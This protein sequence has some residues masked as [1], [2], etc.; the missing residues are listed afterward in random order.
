MVACPTCDQQLPHVMDADRLLEVLKTETPHRELYRG[1]D[2]GWY[3][4]RGGYGRVPPEAVTELLLR[5]AIVSVYSDCPGDAYHVG[6]TIDIPATIA[7][8]KK[9]W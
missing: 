9:T 3:I 1:R 8:R 6:R 2:G 5:K 4:T 7:L